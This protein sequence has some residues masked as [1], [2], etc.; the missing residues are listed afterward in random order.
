M[1]GFTIQHISLALLIFTAVLSLQG[2]IFR[3]QTGIR[4][5]VEQLDDILVTGT[6]KLKPIV[7]SLSYRPWIW[8]SK[9]KVEVKFYNTRQSLASVSSPHT[10]PLWWLND[11]E[12][13]QLMKALRNLDGIEAAKVTKEGILFTS[14][15]NN[16]ARIRRATQSVMRVIRMSYEHRK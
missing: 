11:T 15:S 6:S 14:R 3:V 5:S 12:Q 7:H 2:Y 8:P 9:N 4:E 13:T 1:T 16:S 10:A